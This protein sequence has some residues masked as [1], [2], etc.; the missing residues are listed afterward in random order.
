MPRPARNAELRCGRVRHMRLYMEKRQQRY[1]SHYAWERVEPRC[2]RRE[3]PI[4]LRF[5]LIRLTI[6]SA[7]SA[8]SPALIRSV[9]DAP[10]MPAAGFSDLACLFGMREQRSLNSRALPLT[11]SHPIRPQ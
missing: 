1:R 3:M 6:K 2:Y 10:N 7:R 11:R 9:P 5:A 4:G 8:P